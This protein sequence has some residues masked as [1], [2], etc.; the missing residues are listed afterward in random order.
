MTTMTTRVIV[1]DKVT[2]AVFN[3]TVEE[4]Q[5]L[6]KYRSVS[7]DIDEKVKNAISNVIIKLVDEY[8][9]RSNLTVFDKGVFCACISA[10]INGSNAISV[11][12]I[13]R[14]LGGSETN[15]IPNLMAK[16][17]EDSLVRLMSCIVSVDCSQLARKSKYKFRKTF[18]R[19][20]ILPGTYEEGNINGKK[21]KVFRFYED[22]PLFEIAEIKGQ[23][24]NVP[25][26][27]Y[28]VENLNHTPRVVSIKEY[29]VQRVVEYQRAKDKRHL[30]NFILFS[31]IFHAAEIDESNKL[32]RQTARNSIKAILDSLVDNHILDSYDFVLRGK[33]YHS[34]KFSVVDGFIDKDISVGDLISLNS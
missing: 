25:L 21:I 7:I 34:I 20:P 4:N 5:D 16:S 11:N 2:K 26:D 27:A 22:S 13:Y 18:F 1:N 28:K 17:I 9:G 8:T 19:A 15:T 23:V 12:Q 6:E 29:V 30:S 24:L 3:M 33:H 14:Y 31:E 32:Q 10:Q